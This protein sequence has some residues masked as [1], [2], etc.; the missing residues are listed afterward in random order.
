LFNGNTSSQTNAIGTEIDMLKFAFLGLAH[1]LGK[2]QASSFHDSTSPH[3]ERREGGMRGGGHENGGGTVRANLIF[4][5]AKLFHPIGGLQQFGQGHGSV[6]TK[7]TFA[8]EFPFP[9][10]NCKVK[11][12]N[13]SQCAII[14]VSDEYIRECQHV[15]IVKV[16]RDAK[17]GK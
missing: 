1:G 6:R 16:P 9:G 14:A 10:S 15:G 17:R 3:H 2:G 4:R 12:S 11:S 13:V 5:D 8:V 7:A